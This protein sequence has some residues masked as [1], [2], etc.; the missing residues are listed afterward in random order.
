MFEGDF[1]GG[2]V[3]EVVDVGEDFGWGGGDGGDVWFGEYDEDL[4]GE[5]FDEVGDGEGVEVWLGFGGVEENVDEVWGVGGEEVVEVCVD[6]DVEG[7]VIVG[8]V[9]EGELEFVGYYVMC[10]VG[11][12][13]KFGDDGDFL[14]G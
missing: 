11:I 8:G 13:E 10:F 3:D 7:E 12:I 14:V 5:G 2:V 1:D 4:L 6:K 9:V